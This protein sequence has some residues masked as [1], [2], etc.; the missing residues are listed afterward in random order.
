MKAGADRLMCRIVPALFHHLLP[1]R[2]SLHR[3]P[4]APRW[5]G[6]PQG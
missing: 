4:T 1:Q 3:T 5:G 2:S 6:V